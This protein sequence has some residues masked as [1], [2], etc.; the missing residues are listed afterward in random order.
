MEKLD[1]NDKEK[2]SHSVE[3]LFS[4]EPEYKAIPEQQD[5]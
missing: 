1:K 4:I 3:A 5:L 2:E